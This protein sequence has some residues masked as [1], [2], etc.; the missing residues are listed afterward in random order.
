MFL[1]FTYVDA[2]Y[3]NTVNSVIPA[4]ISK[5]NSVGTANISKVNSVS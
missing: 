4:N 1:R 3:S 5:I 2:G